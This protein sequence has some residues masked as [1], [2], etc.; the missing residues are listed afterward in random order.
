MPTYANKE[1]NKTTPFHAS[2]INRIYI[3]P[4]F[5]ALKKMVAHISHTV[6]ATR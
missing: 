4:L 1:N 2:T 5:I 3:T 6:T